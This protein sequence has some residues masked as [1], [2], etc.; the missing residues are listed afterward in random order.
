MKRTLFTALTLPLSLLLAGAVAPAQ[1]GDFPKIPTL[2]TVALIGQ[3]ADDE[4]NAGVEA[5]RNKQYDKA[6]IAFSNAIKKGGAD[7]WVAYYS[8]AE[9]YAALGQQEKAIADYTQVINKKPKLADAYRFRGRSYLKLKQPDKALADYN[10]G[11]SYRPGNTDIIGDR[12]AA[13]LTLKDYAK[14]L[15]DYNVIV[16][17]MKRVKVEDRDPTVWYNRGLAYMQKYQAEQAE[18]KEKPEDVKAALDDFEEYV[19]QATV[20]GQ[21][22]PDVYLSRADAYLL[23]KNYDKAISSYSYVIQKDPKS[24]YAYERRGSAYESNKNF[25]AAL[26]DFQSAI[27]INPTSPTSQTSVTRILLASGNLQDALGLLSKDISNPPK[28][29]QKDKLSS[30]ALVYM[31]L[32]D[33]PNAIR[34]YDTVLKFDPADQAALTNR[35]TAFL[36]T[37]AYDK[38]LVDYDAYIALQ[39][40]PPKD[41]AG[42][43][44][45]LTGKANILMGQ[46]KYDLATSAYTQL[47][48]AKPDDSSLY[49]NRGKAYFN[50]KAYDKALPDVEKY[51]GAKPDD[52]EAAKLK[53]DIEFLIAE[54][55]GP[56]AQ[57][58]VLQKSI[59]KDPTNA[60]YRLNLGSAYFRQMKYDDAISAYSEAIKIKPDDANAFYSRAAAYA[61]KEDWANTA[62]DASSALAVKPD[63]ADAQVLRAQANFSAKNYS[64][65]IKDYEVIYAKDNNNAESLKALAFAYVANKD[66]ANTIRILTNY[67]PK[68]PNDLDAVYNRGVAYVGLMKYPEGIADLTKYI[69][70]G[71]KEQAIALYNRGLAYNKSDKPDLA[72]L[73]FEASLAKKNDYNVALEA[74]KGYALQ[75]DKLRDSNPTG[76]GDLYAKAAAAYAKAAASLDEP[77]S[78]ETDVPK[79]KAEAYRSQGTAL[80]LQ[81][82]ATESVEVMKAS[83]AAYTKYMEIAKPLNLHRKSLTR[84]KTLT[85]TSVASANLSRGIAVGFHDF[86]EAVWPVQCIP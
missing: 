19:A 47:I 11:L 40:T 8:R 31:Q 67:I 57:I 82:S 72:T 3:T 81:G 10:Q 45:A 69:Q 4:F 83:L 21:V 65:A 20:K 62:K 55:A 23:T 18:K 6:I 30:R 52:K 42:V 29:E 60:A 34:D 7:Y 1:A 64:E 74:G 49:Y 59:V 38:A 26:A 79:K 50:M 80:R 27:K 5:Q 16:E 41:P 66:Y 85:A 73:D 44:N 54:K 76:A 53:S 46:Q 2:I 13:Y 68:N 25:T 56:E 39:G 12:A 36:N 9:S 37:N 28:K 43:Q 61:K 15:T 22:S 71:G 78:K 24:S 86:A 77:G 48:V 58:A 75:G 17:K 14:S 32:K 33:Y 84:R 51:V 63:Y 70:G 35:A